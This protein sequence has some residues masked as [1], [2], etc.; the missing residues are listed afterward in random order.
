[1]KIQLGVESLFTTEA[2]R[3]AKVGGRKFAVTLRLQHDAT[4]KQEKIMKHPRH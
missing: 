2:S 4:N 1:M 3:E